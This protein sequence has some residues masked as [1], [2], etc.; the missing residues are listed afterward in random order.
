MCVHCMYAHVCVRR[1][2]LLRLASQCQRHGRGPRPG[3]WLGRRRMPCTLGTSQMNGPRWVGTAD[4]THASTVSINSS[5]TSVPRTTIAPSRKT[6]APPR[7]TPH[8]TAS[9]HTTPP[10]RARDHARVAPVRCIVARCSQEMKKE[11]RRQSRLREQT[12]GQRQRQHQHQHPHQAAA[13]T[14]LAGSNRG[15]G[16]MPLGLTGSTGAGAGGA[17]AADESKQQLVLGE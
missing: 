15:S 3:R 5:H 1:F 17:G 13:N 14:S 6:I 7:T 8:R 11:K 12:D 2:A 9:H 4:S 10:T 16:E